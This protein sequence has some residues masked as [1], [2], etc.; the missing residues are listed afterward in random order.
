MA[1]LVIEHQIYIG[2]DFS[3]DDGKKELKEN[4]LVTLK[5]DT[6]DLEGNSLAVFDTRE[7]AIAFCLYYREHKEANLIYQL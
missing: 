2:F 6:S 3:S 4:Y 5:K 7:D 1:C